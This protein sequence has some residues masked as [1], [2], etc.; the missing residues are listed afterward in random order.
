MGSLTDFSY[1]ISTIEQDF[2]APQNV[3]A[4]IWKESVPN[5]LVSASLPRWWNVSPNELHAVTLYQR[6]GEEIL[7]MASGNQQLETEVVSILSDCIPPQR[8]ERLENA[9]RRKQGAAAILPQMLPAETSYL[10]YELP[11]RFP[12]EAAALGPVS[13]QLEELRKQHPTEVSWERLSR[14]FGV[15][16]PELTRNNARELL[17]IRPFPFA[18]GIS[19][20]LFGE[21]WESSNLYW[22]RLADEMGYAPVSLNLLAPDLTRHMVEKIFATDMEDWPALLRAM[23]E[24]GDEFKRSKVATSSSVSGSSSD[25]TTTAAA[26]GNGSS[27]N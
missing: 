4:L 23:Q 18:G 26:F 15:P 25:A 22:A 19:S 10:A 12:G 9:L 8:L 13:L 24:T 1:A 7:T 11:K 14:D 16:H 2:I 27:T 21:T 3:Q 20:R 6:S 5:L 17:N